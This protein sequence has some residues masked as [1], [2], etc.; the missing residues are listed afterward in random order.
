MAISNLYLNKQVAALGQD[1]IF[2]SFDMYGAKY[3]Y[4]GTGV[5]TLASTKLTPATSPAWT[6]N[7]YQSTV[8]KN[9]FVVDNAGDLCSVAVTSNTATDVTFTPASLKKVKDQTTAGVLTDAATYTFFI[10]TPSAVTDYGEYFGYSK[11][12]EYNPNVNKVPLITGVPEVKVRTD[13]GGI[14]PTMKGIIQNMGIK[15]YKNIMQMINYG[16]QTAYTSQA[17]GS[18]YSVGSYWEVTLVGQTVAGK[19]VVYKFWKT[20]LSL[21]GGVNFGEA[22][23]KTVPFMVDV[24]LS[25]YVE[26]TQANMV[27]IITQS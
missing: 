15:Q 8:K 23:H 25:N 6:I 11:L 16:L 19:T 7:D 9:L 27:Q 10:L 26:N 2:Q 5:Y 22:A 12:G 13:I 14:Q 20:N 4:E 21:D 24:L 18:N 1:I 17:L 3:E